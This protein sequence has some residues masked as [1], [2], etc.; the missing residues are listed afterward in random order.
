MVYTVTVSQSV[1]SIYHWNIVS[2]KRRDIVLSQIYHFYC[3][4]K[5]ICGFTQN[6][7]TAHDQSLLIYDFIYTK[8]M[9]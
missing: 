7:I 1:D 2:L 9:T 8:C 5:L 3:F 4:Y 6:F